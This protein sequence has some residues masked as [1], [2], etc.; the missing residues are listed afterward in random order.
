[1]MT[2]FT[3]FIMFLAILITS[4]LNSQS[5]T[6]EVGK[7]GVGP[8]LGYFRAAD[9]DNGSVMGG[10]FIRARFSELVGMDLSINY[11]SEDYGSG[12]VE[13]SQWPVLLSG[14]FYPVP[15]IYGLVG[16]GM[17]FSSFTYDTQNVIDLPDETSSDF[18]FHVGAGFELAMS[19]QMKLFVDFKY[20]ITDYGFPDFDEIRASDFSANYYLINVGLMFVL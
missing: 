19:R 8:Q 11:R 5:R 7:V 9:A 10:A 17:Y 3:V 6:T 2:R 16:V 13:V 14:L 20:A 1:M 12:R 18:G 4:E 15:G